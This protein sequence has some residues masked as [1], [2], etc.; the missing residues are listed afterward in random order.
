MDIFIEELVKRKR[1]P[2]DYLLAVGIVPLAIVL[3]FTVLGMLL[4]TSSY[5]GIIIIILAVAA[6]YGAHYVIG[7]SNVEYEYSLANTY[8]DVDKITNKNK[9]KKLATASIRNLESFGTKNNPDFG[10]Y[11][12]NPDVTKVYACRE[13]A[14]DDV[15][16]II[17][18]QGEKKMMLIFTPSERIIE[19]ITKR[20]PQKQFI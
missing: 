12:K 8:I 14:A 2:S 17:Y 1:T 13:L 10:K 15:F 20:N 16:F 19:Q 7:L 18:R 5:F 9:R 4:P 11:I 3:I 6:M